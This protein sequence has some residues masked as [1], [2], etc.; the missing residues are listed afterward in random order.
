MGIIIIT[1]QT[2]TGKTKLAL[3]FAL[4]TNGV[5]INCDSRQ[6]YKHLDIITGKDIKNIYLIDIVDPKKYFSS[7][8]Y[9]QKATPFIQTLLSKDK[10]PIIVGGTYLYLC[11]L[12]YGIETDSIKPNWNLRKQLEKKSVKELQKELCTSNIRIFEAMNQSDQ[13]NPRRLIRKIEIAQN[14][15]ELGIKNYEFKKRTK[16]LFQINKIKFIGLKHKNREELVDR[17]QKRVQKRLRQGAIQEV[18]NLLKKG[19]F[20]TDP[21][22][23]TIGYKQIIQFLKG[24]VSKEQAIQEWITKEI[25]YAKRQYTFMKKDKNI[26]WQS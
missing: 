23:Q 8:D 9:V 20:E 2:A 22:M 19:Y 21:G 4:Q 10:T 14:N 1:G 3:Q 17:I 6:V 5:L 26:K 15:L 16:S 13:N 7:F 12:L 11:H 24:T 18:Q 25:Q